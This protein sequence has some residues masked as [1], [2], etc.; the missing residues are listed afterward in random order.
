M[1]TIELTLLNFLIPLYIIIHKCL[2]DNTTS[3]AAISVARKAISAV[4]V[5]RRDPHP[6]ATTVARRG[7]LVA[8]VRASTQKNSQ[9]SKNSRR[10]K[11]SLKNRK[12]NQR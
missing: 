5:P 1:P 12:R 10:S 3:L 6:V 4:T 2:T 11:R 9:R 8:T 7:I